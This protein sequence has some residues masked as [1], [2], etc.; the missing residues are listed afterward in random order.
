MSIVTILGSGTS[1][2]I[3][4]LGC[5]C[6]VCLS[7]NIY[8]NRMR[9]SILIETKNQK[10]IIIDTSPDMRSQ[11]LRNNTK[12]IDAAIITHDHADHIHGIDDLRPFCFDNP[13]K[14]IPIYTD[15]HTKSALENR[16]SYIFDNQM[17]IIGGGIPLLYIDKVDFKNHNIIEKIIEGEKFIFF[18]LPHGRVETL[19][20]KHNGLA[21]LPDC[22]DIPKDIVNYL[23]T[24][25]ID[26]MLIDCVEYNEHQTHLHVSKSFEFIKRIR[27]NRAGLIHM[28]HHISHE[29]ITKECIC[30]IGDHAF[31]TYDTMKLNY[32]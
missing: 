14:K 4:V 15:A 9:T 23:K 17:P 24:S 3:P 13:N 16:F 28:G 22:N 5:S 11:L 30:E 25:K 26:L 19:G 8:D 12:K 6:K 18:K 29:K 10:Y 32:T 7:D 1:T 31:P 2:G 27:P 20:V 21:Y